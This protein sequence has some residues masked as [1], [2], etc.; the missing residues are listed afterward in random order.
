MRRYL[1]IY[2]YISDNFNTKSVDSK[3]TQ[4]NVGTGDTVSIDNGKLSIVRTNKDDELR[5]SQTF[6]SSETDSSDKSVIMKLDISDLETDAGNHHNIELDVY[7]KNTDGGN[8]RGA[9]IRLY[10]TS[11]SQIRLQSRIYYTSSS[12]SATQADVSTSVTDIYIKF[13]K[14]GNEFYTQYSLDGSTYVTLDHKTLVNYDYFYQIQIGVDQEYTTSTT[15]LVDYVNVS[16]DED[17]FYD[18]QID[19]KDAGHIKEYTKS[20]VAINEYDY[21][22][23]NGIRK[24]K[25]TYR[26]RFIYKYSF[27]DDTSV[28][29]DIFDAFLQHYDIYLYSSDMFNERVMLNDISY[30]YI[31]N[32]S[33]NPYLD[34]VFDSLQTT[35]DVNNDSIDDIDTMIN[36]NG[37]ELYGNDE[38]TYKITCGPG[39]GVIGVYIKTGTD[40]GLPM[41]VTYLIG[42][43]MRGRITLRAR[44][45]APGKGA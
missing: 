31:R 35:D 6:T 15:L 18:S 25:N 40:Y 16:P 37:I 20:A 39:C 32:K 23:V 42:A 43:G 27:I 29:D 3:W 33:F 19:L 14:S 22:T 21:R 9:F 36:D 30:N 38:Q 8:E 1:N 5:L 10:R 12:S 34:L 17:S 13:Y 24:I 11:T 4:A 7:Y 28:V 26:N 2:K 41:K 45:P 44:R